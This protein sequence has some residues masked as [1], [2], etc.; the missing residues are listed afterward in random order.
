MRG[1]D[2]ITAFWAGNFRFW[3]LGGKVQ[4]CA[5]A[6][7][8]KIAAH[9]MAVRRLLPLRKGGHDGTTASRVGHPR[10]E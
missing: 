1:A 6:V 9:T 3:Q 7:P 2:H 4:S 8:K 10:K 5:T